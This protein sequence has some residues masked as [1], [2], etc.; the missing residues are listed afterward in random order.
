VN[1]APIDLVRKILDAVEAKEQ[2]ARVAT[3][4]PW[5]YNPRKVWHPPGELARPPLQRMGGEEF[6]GASRFHATVAVAVTGPANHP[7]SMADAMFIADN[8]PDEI[9]HRCATDREMLALHHPDPH[10]GL[11]NTCGLDGQNLDCTY[12]CDTIRVLARAHRVQP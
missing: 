10:D 11:C 9:L 5:H 4:G 12:P 8:G 7:Q 3:R 1:A 6:V 2:R